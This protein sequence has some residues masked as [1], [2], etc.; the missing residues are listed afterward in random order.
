MEVVAATMTSCPPFVI[1]VARMNIG[2]DQPFAPPSHRT[3]CKP[4]ADTVTSRGFARQ[5]TNNG[6][7][8]R[9]PNP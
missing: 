5:K 4:Q 9:R 6:H 8:Q 1:A 2:L 3:I 7:L